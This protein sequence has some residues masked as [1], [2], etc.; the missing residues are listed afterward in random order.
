MAIPSPDALPFDAPRYLS[1][2]QPLLTLPRETL[3]RVTAEAA[4]AALGGVAAE[5]GAELVV[6]DGAAPVFL[7]LPPGPPA[8]TVF[9]TWH[10][11]SA[12]V[13]TAAVEGAERLALAAALA[14][15]GAAREGAMAAGAAL[16]AAVVVA[17]AASHGS[18]VLSELLARHRERLA[19]PV[20]LWPR[21]GAD[22][23]ARRRIFLGARGRVVLGLRGE[24]PPDAAAA[25]R[26][27]VVR[28]LSDEAYGPRPLDFEL[29]RK[30]ARSGDAMA[31]LERSVGDARTVA[32]DGEI[33]LR[34]ALFE[35]RGEV[36]APAVP[37]ADRPS[38]W[39]V[40]TTAEQMEAAD[41]RARV[42]ALAPGA[43]V[44]VAEAC[45]WDR[46]GIHHPSV[47][48]AVRESKRWSEGPDIW[49]MSPW[50]TPSGIF[51]RALGTPLLE[52]A[53]PLPE[54]GMIR[55]PKPEIF[56]SIR[57]EIAGLLLRGAGL[58]SQDEDSRS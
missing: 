44:E 22:T 29:L 1:R 26:D 58:L 4:R 48:A 38:A 9:A 53:V 50:P 34:N 2:F 6:G 43:R 20:A 15:L 42:E 18:L 41:I 10:A 31:F 3:P 23:P 51:T 27:Q 13:A 19:A 47:Q 5:L 24:V 56:E 12:P 54:G 52:W 8:V 40:F 57:R 14:A 37:H 49:P 55:F 46:I 33:R 25:I 11:E 36:L 7:L 16:P 21:I 28:A 30:L 32:G 39:L 17:P 45:P 35:P